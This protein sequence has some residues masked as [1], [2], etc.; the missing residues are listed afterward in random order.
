MKDAQVTAV[1]EDDALDLLE[2]LG[3]GVDYRAGRLRCS[4]CGTPLLENGLGAARKA[5]DGTFEFACERLDCLEEFH[6]S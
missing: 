2:L 5:E 3:V 4:V 6:A 1:H